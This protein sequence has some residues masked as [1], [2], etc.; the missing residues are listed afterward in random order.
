IPTQSASP[1]LVL[2]YDKPATQW[3]EALPIGNGR[4]GAMI[5]GG[6]ASERLQLNHDTLWSGAPSDW[7]NPRAK[8]VLPELRALIFAGKYAE[9]DQLARQLQGPYGQ[10]YLPMGDLQLMFDHGASPDAYQ[11]WLDLDSAMASV[12]YTLD[13]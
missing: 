5:F 9:A 7:N 12:R 3:V 11:R 6:V 4:V 8:E 10:S 1:P 2:W 13:G